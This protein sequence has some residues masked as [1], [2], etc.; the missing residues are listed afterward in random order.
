MVFKCRDS[1]RATWQ[2]NGKRRTKSFP[3]KNEAALFEAE[4]KAGVTTVL[5]R[6]QEST[7]FAQWAAKWFEIYAKVEKSETT[8]AHDEAAIRMHLNPVLGHLK[9]QEIRKS[10]GNDLKAAL[11][12]K[13]LNPKT[14][15][16]YLILA[17]K[18]LNVA[19]DFELIPASPF[20]LVKNLKAPKAKFAYWTSEESE[21]FLTRCRPLDP[22]LADIVTVALRTGMR[23][24]EMMALQRQDL[25]F[26]HK[27]IRIAAT[28]SRPLGKRFERSKNFDVGYARMTGEVFEILSAIK[29]LKPEQFVFRHEKMRF[30][31]RDLR[32]MCER[33]RVQTLS[34]H[35]LRHSFASQLA[36]AGV[37]I[38][39]IQKMM[40]H[41]TVQMTERYAHLTIDDLRAAVAVLEKPHALRPQD[42]SEAPSKLKVS[43]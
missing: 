12:A 9:L 33:A 35:G 8:W 37:D 17:K 25:D 43:N 40:R 10:H 29:L 41:K 21:K 26:E 11:V 7:T 27:L 24:G 1:W 34:P 22:E 38:F 19:V 6:E 36:A 31:R 3:S 14:A 23:I 32:K 13:G 20:Q 30:F 2:E 39:K 16:N 5:T 15:N 18:I 28:W 42:S 4:L